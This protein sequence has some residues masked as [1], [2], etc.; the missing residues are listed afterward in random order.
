[1]PLIEARL[2]EGSETLLSYNGKPYTRSR[3]YSEWGKLMTSLD[4]RHTPHECRHTFRSL[5]DSA[6]ANKRC[7]DLIMGHKSRDVGERVYTHKT[8]KELKQAVMLIDVKK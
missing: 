8:I 4:M 1:M 7:I 3:F 5:L 6:G 2:A